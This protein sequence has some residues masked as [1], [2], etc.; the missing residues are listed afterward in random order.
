MAINKSKRTMSIIFFFGIIVMFSSVSLL[1]ANAAFIVNNEI[2]EG[3]AAAGIPL[4]GLSPAAAEKKLGTA[5]NNKITGQQ[6]TVTYKGQTWPITAET[7]QPNID[8]PAIVKQAY[9]AGRTGNIWQRLRDRYTIFTHGYSVPL[10]LNYDRQKLT[11]AIEKIAGEINQE[12]QNAIIIE[13]GRELSIVPEVTGRK[14]DIEQTLTDLIDNLI[15]F[16]FE[17]PLAVTETTPT[18]LSSDLTDIDGIIAS[19]TTQ[20]NPADTNRSHNVYLAAKSINGLLV[21]S[22]ELFS[23]NSVTG[24]RLAQYGY[25]I[26]PT[27]VNGELVPD[28]GGGVCQVSSTLYNAVLLADL[29]IVERTPHYHPPAYV[30]LGQDATVADNTLDFKFKNTTGHN[31]YISASTAGNKLTVTLYGKRNNNLVDIDIVATD[32]QTLEPNTVIEQDPDLELGKK[33]ITEP[34]QKGFIVTTCRVK[35][36]NGK[37]LEREILATDEFKPITRT[38]RLGTKVYTARGSK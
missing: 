35:S 38:V 15:K 7:F 27:Y 34:G 9:E 3:V 36:R 2:Y 31:I 23:F 1:A 20:F 19:Y 37:I 32:I 21:R 6:L 10:Y 28:W 16:N 11:A 8:T 22:G 12:A 14:V 17:I 18:V 24:L 4:G 26:A 13:K 33:I 5:F 30:P 29:A 25:K